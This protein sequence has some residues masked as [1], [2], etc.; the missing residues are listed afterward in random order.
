VRSPAFICLV[1]GAAGKPDSAWFHN[2]LP[3]LGY[4]LHAALPSSFNQLLSRDIDPH[5]LLQVRLRKT[6]LHTIMMV[7][8]NLIVYSL[9]PPV[10]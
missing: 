6:C 4:I 9:A 10:G 7:T 3:S 1:R 5:P 8:I 2:A